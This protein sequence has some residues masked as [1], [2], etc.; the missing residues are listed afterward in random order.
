MK[1]EGVAVK[2]QYQWHYH[3]NQRMLSKMEAGQTLRF[4]K[5][6]K[7]LPLVF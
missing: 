6:L 3:S 7:V 2:S 4:L 5:L 1:L